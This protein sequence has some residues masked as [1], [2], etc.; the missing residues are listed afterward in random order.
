MSIKSAGEMRERLTITGVVKIDNGRGG[1]TTQ[2][3]TIGTFWAYIEQQSAK[4][5]IRYNSEDTRVK[6]QIVTRYHP[7]IKPGVEYEG[8][9]RDGRK[10]EMG[11][12]IKRT[13]APRGYEF[14]A[15]EVY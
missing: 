14:A 5:V 3:Q 7:A 9:T 13:K 10:F 8:R 11:A 4:E 12:A 6:S 1:W 2:K 15:E